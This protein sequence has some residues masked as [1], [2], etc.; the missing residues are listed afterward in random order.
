MASLDAQPRPAEAVVRA[1]VQ[2]GSPFRK[3]PNTEPTVL[4]VPL[5]QGVAGSIPARPPNDYR[6]F[7]DPQADRR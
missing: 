2:I 7:L 4:P 1:A 3:V 6:L 5:N